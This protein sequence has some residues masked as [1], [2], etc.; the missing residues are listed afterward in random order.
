MT[1]LRLGAIQALTQGRRPNAGL[2]SNTG[3]CQ[4][5][6][7]EYKVLGIGGR[8]FQLEIPCIPVRE[9]Q[10]DNRST[11]PIYLQ[12]TSV[13]RSTCSPHTYATDAQLSKL[14]SSRIYRQFA[15]ADCG[16]C[17]QPFSL[18]QT[19]AGA[20]SKYVDMPHR[21]CISYSV[22]NDR[23]QTAILFC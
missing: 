12:R 18:T 3:L 10:T 4:F 7:V 13:F 14:H 5:R 2:L 15:D 21:P 1:L 17:R 19:T 11:L 8:L 22:F 20:L 16:S 9:E 6:S 23:S